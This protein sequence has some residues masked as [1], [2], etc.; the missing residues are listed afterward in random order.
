MEKPGATLERGAE[1]LLVDVRTSAEMDD[2]DSKGGGDDVGNGGGVSEWE[3]DEGDFGKAV[4]A[5]TTEEGF[6]KKLKASG[7]GANV[8][9]EEDAIPPSPIPILAD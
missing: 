3:G 5:A 6:D 8:D 2:D 4:A 1:F 9:I 7:D